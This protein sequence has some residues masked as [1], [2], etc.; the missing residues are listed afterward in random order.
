MSAVTPAGAPVD[1]LAAACR[2]ETAMGKQMHRWLGNEVDDFIGTSGDVA[3]G[4]HIYS[5]HWLR[6]INGELETVRKP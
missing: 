4:R 1:S 2:C 5:F 3:N 6:A